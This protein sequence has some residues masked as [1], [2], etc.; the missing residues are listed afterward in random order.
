MTFMKLLTF[1]T[2]SV[3]YIAAQSYAAQ[4]IE[5]E[6]DFRQTMI[7]ANVL[8]LRCN[9]LN[10]RRQKKV[11]HKQRLQGLIARNMKVLQ[12]I[13]IK[14]DPEFYNKMTKTGIRLRY[15]ME[16]AL[17]KIINSEEDLVRTGCPNLLLQ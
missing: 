12:L 4:F 13:D 15:E 17:Q 14:E 5:E 2:I 3:L 8:S 10:S 16:L 6:D 11:Q 1:L 7:E 9:E